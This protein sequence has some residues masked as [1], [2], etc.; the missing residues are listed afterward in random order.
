MRIDFHFRPDIVVVEPQGRL[1]IET[2]EHL[3]AT[4]KRLQDAGF[5]RFVLNLSYVP[6]IDSCGLGAIA[7]AYA[8][9]LA[10]GG[11][12]KLAGV[13]PRNLQLLRVTNLSTVFEVF[14][15]RDEALRSFGPTDSEGREQPGC[16]IDVSLG[17]QEVFL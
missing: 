9:S 8:S 4:I 13:N 14:T 1:T 5:V 3:T 11:K 15:S 17:R 12:L 2:E 6:V 7:E 16:T 10:H